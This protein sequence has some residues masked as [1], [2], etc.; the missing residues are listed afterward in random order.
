M[1]TVDVLRRAKEILSD[2]A[3]WY[4]GNYNGPN[5]SMCALQAIRRGSGAFDILDE[6]ERTETAR[7][8]LIAVLG[9]RYGDEVGI[10]NDN[11]ATTHADL[12]DAFDRAILTEYEKAGREREGEAAQAVAPVADACEAVLG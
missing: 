5:G 2:P 8:A 4:K 3:R 11:K 12:I 6:N 9:F 10:W 1:E 7:D